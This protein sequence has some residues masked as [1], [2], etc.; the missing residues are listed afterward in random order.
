[1]YY[2]LSVIHI[3]FSPLRA[4]KEDIPALAQQFLEKYGRINQKEIRGI[5]GD[6][7]EVLLSWDWTGN[8][9]ELETVIERGVIFCKS[10]LLA[11]PD[12]IL[13][14]RP[15]STLLAIEEEIFSRPIKEARE[16][17]ISHFNAEYIKLTF[18]QT[19]GQCLSGGPQ[20]IG[21]KRP[22]LH[23]LMKES[24][25]KAKAFKQID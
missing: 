16:R 1:M 10:G 3:P 11:I 20:E 24:D 14:D 15:T 7:L 5:H 17:L 19:Q 13:P 9:R 2:R 25:I 22:Y 21:F 18:G 23:R 12:L 6:A 4:R 8:I